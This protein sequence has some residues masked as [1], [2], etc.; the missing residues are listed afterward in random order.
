MKPANIFSFVAEKSFHDMSKAY[1]RQH[2]CV[3][4]KEETGEVT[5]ASQSN[6]MAA[7]RRW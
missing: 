2:F 3:I 7:S 1:A 4:R 6:L 5:A